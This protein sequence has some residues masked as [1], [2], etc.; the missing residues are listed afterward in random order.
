M[1][2]DVGALWENFMVSERIKQ[3]S[4]NRDFRKIYFWRTQTQ[5][6]IDLLEEKDG[7]LYAFEF[8]WN[9]KKHANIPMSFADAYPE[10]RFE[11]IT[12][13]N[14]IDLLMREQ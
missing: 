9:P 4:Y 6:E 12:F 7:V 8:K 3:N 11:V 2:Q 13:G 10:H 5:Q 1:V 14:Y